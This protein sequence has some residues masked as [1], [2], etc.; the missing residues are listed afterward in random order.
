MRTTLSAILLGFT[1]LG[2]SACGGATPP[3]NAPAASAAK[4]APGE[5]KVGDTTTCPVSGEEF[6]VTAESP[7]IEYEGKTYYTCCSGCAKKLK[8][9]PKKY[10]SKPHS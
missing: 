1:L 3:A 7:H 10:L 6:V 2:L 5:A 8:E 4:K 9:D